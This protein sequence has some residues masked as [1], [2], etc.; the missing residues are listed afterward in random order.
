MQNLFCRKWLILCALLSA[1]QS[2]ATVEK[3]DSPT[4]QTFSIQIENIVLNSHKVNIGFVKPRLTG[5]DDVSGILHLVGDPELPVIRF[6]LDG[7]GEISVTSDSSPEFVSL[8]QGNLLYP[9]QEAVP[10]IKGQERIFTKNDAAYNVDKF[11]P[12]RFT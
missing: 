9:S 12:A 7:D 10:K 6:F 5:I 11:F 2:L 8:P 1:N 4:G 3:D